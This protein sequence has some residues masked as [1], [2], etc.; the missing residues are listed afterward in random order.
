MQKISS[1]F[2]PNLPRFAQISNSHCGPA[3]LSMLL[4]NLGV[5]VRQKDIVPAAKLTVK[6]IN[7]F[8][9]TVWELAEATKK[10]SNFDFWM[11]DNATIQEINKLITKHNCPVAVEWQGEF[12]QYG[13]DD[14]GHYSVVTEISKKDN[15]IYIA[16]PYKHFS[17]KDR[18]LKLTRFQELWWDI[19][20][21]KNPATKKLELIKDYHLIF[22]IIPKGATFPIDLGMELL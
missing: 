12:L 22:I 8:G 17:G 21:I 11:K 14:S 7:D 15:S 20:E 3:T 13:D 19:N 5:K 1:R 6:K 10:L 2:F 9:V 4:A 16:D 18:K